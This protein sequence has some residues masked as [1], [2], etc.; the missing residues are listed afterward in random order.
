MT[1]KTDFNTSSERKRPVTGRPLLVGL[2]VL[3]AAFAGA[4]WMVKTKPKAKPMEAPPVIPLVEVCSLMPTSATV[5][6]EAMGV[7]MAKEE[8]AVQAEVSGVITGKHPELAEGGFVRQEEVLIQ[9][10]DRNYRYA[11][12]QKKAA[13]DTAKSNLRMEMGQQDIA[14]K[15]WALIA[16]AEAPVELDME[17]AL[18]EPQRLAKEADILSAQAAMD[19]AQLDLERTRITAPFNAVVTEAEAS[20]GDQA[21]TGTVLARLVDTDVFWIKIK[22]RVDQLKWIRFPRDDQAGSV[23]TIYME[24]G[25]LRHG[26][27]VK[28]LAEL[29][30]T[31]RMAQ[32]LVAVEDPLNRAETPDTPALLLNQ[33]VRV[34]VEGVRINAVYCIPRTALHDGSV[35]WLLDADNHLRIVP[36]EI[37]WSTKEEIFIRNAFEQGQRMVLSNLGAP[38][39]G[40]TLAAEGAQ[41]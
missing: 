7:V 25:A 8:V 23:V 35:L 24:N 12:Q 27:V 4:V 11:L 31:S 6:V 40:M 28:L 9:L 18:R 3:I 5:M 13:L 41:P 17:L 19:R 34:E 2:F 22:V 26:Q 20:I 39:E 36:A 32:L 15:E 38:V 33:Y 37:V 10:D 21:N 30:P 1:T 29:D 16:G 14:Q